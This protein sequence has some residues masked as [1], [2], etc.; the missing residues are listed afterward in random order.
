MRRR[1]L[2]R[3]QSSGRS[4]DNIVSIKKR[5]DTFVQTSMPVVE[6]YA[7]KNKVYKV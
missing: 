1:L 3:G 4:D 5:F 2:T 6:Y 7:S